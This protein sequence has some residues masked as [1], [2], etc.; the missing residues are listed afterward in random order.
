[1]S[2]PSR[3]HFWSGWPE[4]S[5]KRFFKLAL[6]GTLVLA[7]CVFV[8]LKLVGNSLELEIG[9]AKE[10][11]GRVLPLVREV[12][13][14]R[15]QMGNLAHLPVEEA[16]WVIIDDLSIEPNLT[17]FRPA[18]LT[19]DV[20]AVQATFTG[21]PLAKLT[22]FLEALPER[23]SLQT[24]ECVLTRNPDDPRL[25]DLHLVLAR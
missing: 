2:R 19:G 20:K 24:P 13:A 14:L 11:Y 10:Q 5:Q 3:N 6:M 22:S 4:A 1:M 7:A 21:L 17:S 18:V 12:V 9:Q 23:A 8:G 15:A 16:V 25:A